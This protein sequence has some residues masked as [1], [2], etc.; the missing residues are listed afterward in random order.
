MASPAFSPLETL[1]LEISALPDGPA[2]IR[3]KLLKRLIEALIRDRARGG[4]NVDEV[5]THK[6]R[7]F[8]AQPQG[9]DVE[10]TFAWMPIES[11]WKG[12]GSD[13]HSGDRV[14]RFKLCRGKLAGRTPDNMMDEFVAYGNAGD[15]DI[16]EDDAVWTQVYL[17][18]P[19]TEDQLLSGNVSFE[20]GTLKIIEGTDDLEDLL[21]LPGFGEDGSVPAYIVVPLCDVA[22]WGGSLHFYPGY[23]SNLDASIAITGVNAQGGV[24][25]DIFV[26]GSSNNG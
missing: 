12:T 24:G 10:L 1:A 25:R 23:T 17:Q 7:F 21:D 19:V 14:L 18:V 16:E 6:G 20:K 3:G 8:N 9:T 5:P 2:W 26:A 15:S 22:W 4:A 13:P 11:K